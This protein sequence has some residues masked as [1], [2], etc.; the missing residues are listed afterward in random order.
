MEQ[1]ACMIDLIGLQNIQVL[2][3]EH[4]GEDPTISEAFQHCL[5]Q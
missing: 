2:R 3:D 4:P 5:P 1:M